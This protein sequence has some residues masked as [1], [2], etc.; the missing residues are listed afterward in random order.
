MKPCIIEGKSVL[1]K[2]RLFI[3]HQPNELSTI[4]QQSSKIRREC[5]FQGQNLFKL[6]YRV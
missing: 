4:I 6:K 2:N 5:S 3:L 1:G